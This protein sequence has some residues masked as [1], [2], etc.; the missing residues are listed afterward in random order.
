MGMWDEEAWDNDSAAD[1]FADL[2]DETKLRESWLKAIEDD[3]ED[4]YEKIRAAVWL[5]VQLGRVY[6]WPIDDYDKDLEL[7]ISKGESVVAMEGL[8]EEVP[9]YVSKLKAEIEELK[10]RREKD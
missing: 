6:I 4:E 10:G 9:D 2:M 3:A 1:W 7:A 5:F 8:A